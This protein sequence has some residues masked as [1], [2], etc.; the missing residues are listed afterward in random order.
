MITDK[1]LF[2]WFDD[3]FKLFQ[4]IIQLPHLYK[5]IDIPNNYRNIITDLHEVK[6]TSKNSFKI[7]NIIELDDK[8]LIGSHKYEITFTNIQKQILTGYFNECERLYNICI[9]IWKKYPEVTH[10]WKLLK[11]VIFKKV[12]R[13]LISVTNLDDTIENIIL[14]LKKIREIYELNNQQYKEQITQTKIKINEEH[15]KQLNIWKTKVNEAKKKGIILKELAPKKPKVKINKIKEP[16]KPKGNVIKKPAPDETLKGVI[17]TFC[18]DL[19]EN[20]TRKI[21]D[22]NFN[23]EMNYKDTKNR[24]TIIVSNRNISKDGIFINSMGKL[25]C[26][27]W[28]K[29]TDK[30][31]IEKECL[32]THNKQLNKY[33]LHIVFNKK[34]KTIKNRKKIVAIDEGEKIFLTFYSENNYGKIGDNMRVKIIKLLRKKNKIQSLLDKGKNW[35]GD[36]ITNIKR[37]K[38]KMAKI[39]AKIEGYVN[40]IHKK[41]AKYLCENYEVII[42]PEFKTKPMISNRKK[43]EEINRV[44]FIKNDEEK[45]REL[46][47]LN[48]IKKISREVKNVLNMQSH[49]Q[50]KKYLK[51]KAKEYK[52]IV[53]DT[54]EEYT[55]Q[56]CTKCG[57]LGKQYSQ[58]R[59]KECEC[60]YKVD[61]DIN[62]ARNILIKSIRKIGNIID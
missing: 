5:K 18:K 2:D 50:F 36:T 40:D 38:I 6:K 25:E 14:D 20:R 52:T 28:K 3:D 23:F 17:K 33:Y 4:N 37:L 1:L 57:K 46:N 29:I 60:G 42:I 55:S 59:E 61:R 32:L 31:K 13:S 47:K 49:Y 58:K 44:M 51:A 53:Y 10:N 16:K 27:Q 15:K 24:H 41:A 48:K 43:E 62:G 45:Q 34:Y 8:D 11:D 30:Y 12:Y 56:C 19:E 39:Y 26:K 35:Y 9:D 7:D 54:T 22:K 21:K